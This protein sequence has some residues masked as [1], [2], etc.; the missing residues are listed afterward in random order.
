MFVPVWQNVQLTDENGRATADSEI[1]FG[2]LNREMQ[3]NVSNDGF[4][5]PSRTTS[6]IDQILLDANPESQKPNGTMLYDS[7][8]DELKIKSAGVVRIIQFI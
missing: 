4:V 8:T 6:E 7:D 5:I 2:T 3:A 1:F